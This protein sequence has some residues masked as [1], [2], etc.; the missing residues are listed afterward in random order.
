MNKI[1]EALVGW[2]GPRCTTF[3]EDCPCCQAWAEYDAM[4]ARLLIAD[5]AISRV[6]QRETEE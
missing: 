5:Y 3:E 4:G 6:Y 1:E 2:W